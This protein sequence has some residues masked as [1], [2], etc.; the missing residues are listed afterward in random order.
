VATA[1]VVVSDVPAYA[2]A[3]G[4][5]AKVIRMRYDAPTVE[6]LLEIAWWDWPSDKIGRNLDALRRSDL[7]TLEAAR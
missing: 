6:R 1:S 7:G 4:N 2:V 3:G 5:P